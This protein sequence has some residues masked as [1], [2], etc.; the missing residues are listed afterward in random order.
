MVL[1]PG[2]TVAYGF[3]LSFSMY[4]FTA[5]GVLLALAVFAVSHPRKRGPLGLIPI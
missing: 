1:L 4:C 5:D 2:V 3:F